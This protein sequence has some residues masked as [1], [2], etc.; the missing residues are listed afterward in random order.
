MANMSYCQ[1]ENT[2]PDLRQ[3][4]TA[5]T[6]REVS[7]ESE[8]NLARKMLVEFLDFCEGE[9]IIYEVNYGNIDELLDEQ[10]ATQ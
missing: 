10:E 6:N 2:L 5:L 9:G 8:K 7:E 1:F 3:C 4:L